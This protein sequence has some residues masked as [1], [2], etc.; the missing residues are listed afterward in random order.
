MTNVAL[1]RAD[2]PDGPPIGESRARVL[3]MLQL[4]SAP[5]GVGEIAARVGLHPNTVRFHLDGL[6]EQG[7]AKRSKEAREV[8]GRPRALFVATTDR[9]PA[10]RRSYRLLAQILTGYLATHVR[11]PEESALEAGTAWGR[12]L[13]DRPEPFRRLDGA[14]ATRSL[15]GVLDDI[16]F[17]P[18]PVTRGRK[19]QILLHHCPF[20]E[21]AEQHPEV[22][23]TVHLGLMRGVLSELDAPLEAARLEPFVEP[24]LC[25]AH[26]TTRPRQG[27][28]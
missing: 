4:A 16:G 14:A 9:Q 26:L 19:R 20:R 1:T 18:E 11:A 15:V 23:C 17:G 24:N 21:A 22:V 28:T 25:T 12:F 10:G 6:V 27:R 7:C 8:P 2:P 3:E 5:L 13:T